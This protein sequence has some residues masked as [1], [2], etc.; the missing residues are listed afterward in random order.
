MQIV[1][2]INDTWQLIDEAYKTPMEGNYHQ[3]A[4]SS[5]GAG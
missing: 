4:A 2:L 3:R 1:R 5:S